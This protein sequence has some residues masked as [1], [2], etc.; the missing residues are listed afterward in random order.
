MFPEF[1]IEVLVRNLTA[2]NIADEPGEEY[3]GEEQGHLKAAYWS[4]ESPGFSLPNTCS[5]SSGV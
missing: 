4:A 3:D 2:D 1:N 5:Y